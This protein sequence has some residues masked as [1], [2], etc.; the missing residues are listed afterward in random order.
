MIKE[1]NDNVTNGPGINFLTL[2][3]DYQSVTGNDEKTDINRKYR[4]NSK[5]D[6]HNRKLL[7][8]KLQEFEEMRLDLCPEVHV[9]YGYSLEALSKN[10]FDKEL[11][12]VKS[13]EMRNN[14]FTQ[15]SV[16]IDL[17]GDVFLYREAGFLN[18]AGNSKFIIGR[19]NKNTDLE[20]VIKTFLNRDN[21]FIGLDGEFSIKNNIVKRNLSILKIKDGKATSVN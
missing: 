16:A 20:D 12:K 4:L 3:D 10:I 19:I 2:R 7:I 14:G 5:M 9:D 17:Y 11:V 21:N 8:E 18:R 13:Y 15:M 6:E 1:I